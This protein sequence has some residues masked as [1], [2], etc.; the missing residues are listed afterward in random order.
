M[1]RSSGFTNRICVR[2]SRARIIKREPPPRIQHASIFIQNLQ[3]PKRS[4]CVVLWSLREERPQEPPKVVSMRAHTHTH[5]KTIPKKRIHAQCVRNT[6]GYVRCDG[7]PNDETPN[8]LLSLA[9]MFRVTTTS[10]THIRNCRRKKSCVGVR[11]RAR[12]RRRNE[13]RAPRH[14]H[15]THTPIAQVWCFSMKFHPTLGS[16]LLCLRTALSHTHS[17]K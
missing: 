6:S 14:R 13:C 8:S 10:N 1:R 2:C 15:T 4:L 11:R 5:T 17:A 12:A 9:P 16:W 3:V 7:C